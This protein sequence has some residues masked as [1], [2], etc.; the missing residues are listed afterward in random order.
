MLDAQG[1]KRA[2][3]HGWL[4]MKKI[5]LNHLVGDISFTYI[6]PGK[7][8]LH[9]FG[10]IFWLEMNHLSQPSIFRGYVSFSGYSN[11]DL[12]LGVICPFLIW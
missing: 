4:W 8:P 2:N 10:T 12:F 7:S 9:F 1:R 3:V 11:L 5:T 6:I